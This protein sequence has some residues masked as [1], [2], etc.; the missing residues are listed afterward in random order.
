[1]NEAQD[2]ASGGSSSEFP[3]TGR[4]AAIDYGTVRIGVA[5]CDPGRSL[6]S[7]IEVYNVRSPKLDAKY[8][9]ELVKQ[10]RLVG[11]VVGLPIHCDGKESQKSQESRTFA[12]WL[13]EETGLP[14]RLFDERFSTA[15]AKERLRTGSMTRKKN[16][17]RLDAVAALVLLESF[18]EACRYH[19]NL[20][21][22][23][24]DETGDGADAIE[25]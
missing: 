20:V 9:R 22:Q 12:R 15:A 8:F 25:D 14:V 11:L 24:I 18:L 4:L 19:G 17:K 5:V 1:M 3:S 2:S 7:P 21:G 6:A 16:K 10:E 13:H 23:S